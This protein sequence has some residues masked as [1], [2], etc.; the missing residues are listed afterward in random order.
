MTTNNNLERFLNL[1][2]QYIPGGEPKNDAVRTALIE[3]FNDT[4][5]KEENFWVAAKE[6]LTFE[7][8]KAKPQKFKGDDTTWGEAVAR[9]TE[10]MR[11]HIEEVVK[12]VPQEAKSTKETG[13]EKED[14]KLIEVDFT[15]RRRKQ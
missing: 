4:A 2:N 6:V 9:I 15:N 13:R 12:A 3:Q 10:P 14:R 7:I 11:R 5:Q 8:W 1:I